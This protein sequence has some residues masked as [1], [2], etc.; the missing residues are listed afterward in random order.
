MDSSG[1]VCDR[2]SLGKQLPMGLMLWPFSG[3]FFC[4]AGAQVHL[5]LLPVVNSCPFWPTGISLS[6][7]LPM[8]LQTGNQN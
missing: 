8:V 7:L 3:V 4:A 6:S 2:L 5:A 1:L